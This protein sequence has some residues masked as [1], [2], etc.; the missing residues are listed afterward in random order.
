MAF[1]VNSP[2]V[3]EKQATERKKIERIRAAVT[4]LRQGRNA[5]AFLLL[6]EPGAEKE[7]AA[8]FAL[9]LCHLRAGEL[10]AAISCLEQA[11]GFLRAMPPQ[12][13]ERLETN[14]TYLKLATKQVAEKCYL[15]PM[16]VDFCVS[17]PKA[18]EQNALLALIDSYCQNG[19][20][21][22]ARRLSSALT[23]PV[24]EDFKNRLLEN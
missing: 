11:L 13:H 18:A 22:Q 14:G 15:N 17:F 9:A 16:D 10:P 20:I 21:E 4:Y 1:N 3:P 6:S 5:E 8:R 19:M 23:G 12:A 2:D 7:P 24:F